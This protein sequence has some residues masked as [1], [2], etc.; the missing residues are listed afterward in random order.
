MMFSWDVFQRT[1]QMTV[2]WC[3]AQDCLV[4]EAMLSKLFDVLMSA[5]TCVHVRL[6]MCIC[7]CAW[8][9]HRGARLW[10]F[11]MGRTWK[12]WALGLQCVVIVHHYYLNYSHDFPADGT[13]LNLLFSAL[14]WHHS[15]NCYLDSGS[16]QGI[17]ILSS[18]TICNGEPLVC[19]HVTRQAMN[20]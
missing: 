4:G 15:I 20:V 19:F 3:K 10:H 13:T 11:L 1:K 2:W 18:V 12:R 9:C 17:Q 16:K 5:E 8:I 6:C 14:M 7:I